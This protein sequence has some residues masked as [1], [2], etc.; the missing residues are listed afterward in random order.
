[1]QHLAYGHDWSYRNDE[2]KEP[3]WR[4]FRDVSESK[5]EKLCFPPIVKYDQNDLIM[6]IFMF[7]LCVYKSV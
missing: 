4:A 6:N 1:M 7:K 3:K 2:N 5:Q